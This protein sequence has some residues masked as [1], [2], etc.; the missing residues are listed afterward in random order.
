MEQNNIYP[1][2]IA[3]SETKLKAKDVCNVEL[4]NYNFIHMG[5]IMNS[6]NAGMF[7]K[8][9][10]YYN[11]CYKF[12]LNLSNCED[13]WVELERQNFKFIVSIVY[14]HPNQNIKSIQTQLENVLEC[15]SKTTSIY[16]IAGDVNVNLL[17]YNTKNEVKK[18]CRY[19]I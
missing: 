11:F 7:V 10:I 6:R 3:L 13:L 17:N 1:G 2:V 16:Y 12:D 15:S 8:E 19:D 14:R 9:F 5:S 18:V 4:Q